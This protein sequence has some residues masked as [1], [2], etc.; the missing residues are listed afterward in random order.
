MIRSNILL[1]EN[2]PFVLIKAGGSNYE[3]G[4]E[5]AEKLG[6]VIEYVWRNLN[7]RRTNIDWHTPVSEYSRVCTWLKNNLEHIAPWMIEEMQGIADNCGMSFEEVILNNHY[8]LLWTTG[9]LCTSISF[10]SEEGPLLGQNLDIGGGDS[11]YLEIVHPKKGYATISD[12][13]AGMAWSPSGLNEKGLAVASSNLFRG[14]NAEKP[15]AHGVPYHF[16][17]RMVLRNCA[18]VP[19]AIKYLKTLPRTIPSNN[20]YQ[21]N[22]IDKDGRSAVIDKIDKLTGI[23]KSEDGLTLTTNISFHPGIIRYCKE[24]DVDPVSQRDSNERANFIRASFS[25]AGRKGSIKLM[26]RLLRSHDEPGRLCRHGNG[27]TKAYTR[28][29][30]I[31]FPKKLEIWG[32]NG[33]PCKLKYEKFNL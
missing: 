30:F 21:L 1:K 29:S 9:G 8:G 26:L 6:S 19:E 16:L 12:G 28:L 7:E 13:F 22:I 5:K 4:K 31:Y 23:R 2:S 18:D 25:K 10:I 33:H 11:Y 3:I 24:G 14:G 15:L 27:P 32:T 17:P 20:G